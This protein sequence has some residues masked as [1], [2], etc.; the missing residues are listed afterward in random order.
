[1]KYTCECCDFDT[2]YNNGYARHLETKKHNHLAEI[3]FSLAEISLT[4]KPMFVDITIKFSNIKEVYVNMWN[5]Q[6]MTS[7]TPLRYSHTSIVSTSILK[8]VQ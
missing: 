6:T 8:S 2:I 5:Q 1:M 4:K 3:S 7:H